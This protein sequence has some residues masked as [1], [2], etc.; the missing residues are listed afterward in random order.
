VLCFLPGAGEIERGLTDVRSAVGADVEVLPLHGSLSA[1]DQDRVMTPLSRRRVILATNIAE[2]SLTVPD[3]RSVVDTG[4]QK[5]ARYDPDRGID[6]LELERI[7]ADAADQRA[8]RAGRLG[9]GRVRRLWDRADRLRAHR[10]AEIHRVDLSDAVLDV[11]AWGG[12]PVTFEWFDPP[13]GDRVEAAVSLLEKL[14]AVRDGRVT[15]LGAR[16]K[17][18]PLH[19]RLARMLLAAG[20][21][22]DVALACA[23]LSERHAAPRHPSTTTSDLLSAVGEAHLVAPHIRDVARRL[24]AMTRDLDLDLA[25]ERGGD[26]TF[27]RAVFSGYPD[28]VARRR[29]PGSPRFLLASGHGAVLGR[30]SGVRDAPFVAAV[31]VQAGRRG[32]GAEATIRIASAIDPSW[33]D[34]TDVRLEH[35]IESG[36]VRAVERTLYGAIVLSERP[37]APDPEESARLLAEA[38]LARALSDADEQLARRL[39]F[40]GLDTD[41][42][43]LVRAAAAGR[44]SLDEIDPR[45]ALEW[46][47]AREL[48]RRAPETIDVP[49]GRTARLVYQEDGTVSAAVKLQ[50]LFGLAES[51]RIGPREQP[52]V[53]EL[54]APNGRAVQTTRDLRSFWNTTYQDVRKELRGRYPRHPWP[55]DPWT[56]PPTA[57]TK[58]RR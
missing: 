41:V 53:F 20:G 57:R 30:E 34:A 38:Y 22:Q 10:D 28:R 46:S 47:A 31:D 49:S 36:R 6:S 17:R 19:P 15:A 40:A 50:E 8:G 35:T 43:S 51:P 18:M 24:T 44:K 23:L 48:D 13:R 42:P 58:P 55:E 3:I 39:R 29:E 12:N 54:L 1:D 4:W 2:T 11:L 14:G 7:P 27:L 45:G 16:M 9:P 33:L 25:E 56:A 26:E 37:A 52:V 21:R 32:D 5:V